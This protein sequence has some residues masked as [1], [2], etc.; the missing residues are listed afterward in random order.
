[1]SVI[2]AS[3]V[4]VP[5]P[6]FSPVALFAQ[7]CVL[8][9]QSLPRL[10]LLALI[11]WAATNIVGFA[12]GVAGAYFGNRTGHY[13]DVARV[14]YFGAG[15]VA[16]IFLVLYMLA[17]HRYQLIGWRRDTW[18]LGLHWSRREG[19]FLLAIIVLGWPVQMAG[20]LFTRAATP[21]YVDRLAALFF[22]ALLSCLVVLARMM[23]VLPAIA[24]DRRK[25]I[26]LAWELGRRHWLTVL[27]FLALSGVVI[28]GI[29]S[30][31]DHFGGM[32]AFIG[33]TV[34]EFV[35]T[36]FLAIGICAAYRRI[37]PPLAK[38]GRPA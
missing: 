37:S 8:F 14:A 30:A 36:G 25:P 11:A 35:S 31:L 3:L 18:R 4:P 15:T 24:E 29:D 2:P 9:G 32:V 21:E 7:T 26:R 12:F 19:L 23:F 1:M 38:K 33:T 28:F 20:P 27:G 16:A 13:D 6:R 10:A 34:M 17:V 22:V 5:E